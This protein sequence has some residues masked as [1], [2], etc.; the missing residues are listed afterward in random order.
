[1]YNLTIL[2]LLYTFKS[3]G[4][5]VVCESISVFRLHVCT[6]GVL[7]C[8]NVRHLWRKK[9]TNYWHRPKNC[10]LIITSWKL[11]QI[12]RLYKYFIIVNFV[13]C[14]FMPKCILQQRQKTKNVKLHFP[15]HHELTMI[16]ISQKEIHRHKDK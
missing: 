8:E 9:K 5:F 13:L 7:F 16:E 14:I 4:L 6:W 1:M 12:T 3:Q 15:C 2:I 10:H 11:I